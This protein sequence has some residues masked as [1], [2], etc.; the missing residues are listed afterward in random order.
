MP[1]NTFP[2]MPTPKFRHPHGRSILTRKSQPQK[3]AALVYF[4]GITKPAPFDPL[5]LMG[6]WW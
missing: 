3:W 6:G 2:K 5:S 4:A 1:K